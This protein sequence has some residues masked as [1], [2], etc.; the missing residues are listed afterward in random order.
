M[1]EVSVSI[2][3]C[4]DRTK[5][6]LPGLEALGERWTPNLSIVTSKDRS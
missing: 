2:D 6:F 3:A 1:M 4:L 5:V